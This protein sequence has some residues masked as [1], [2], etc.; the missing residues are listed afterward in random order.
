MQLSD[1]GVQPVS[2]GEVEPRDTREKAARSWKMVRRSQSYVGIIASLKPRIESVKDSPVFVMHDGVTKSIFAR[3]IRAKGV[4]LP[5]C[6]NVVKMI[7]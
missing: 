1:R 5:C 4:D 3:L 2:K 7:V 6:Q